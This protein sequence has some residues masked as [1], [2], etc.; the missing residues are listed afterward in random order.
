MFLGKVR[1]PVIVPLAALLL[2]WLPARSQAQTVDDFEARTYTD[3]TSTIPYRLFV[4]RTY[5]PKTA[6]P[7][8]LFLHG[9]GER[10]TDNRRQ[11][12]GQTAPLVFVRPEHQE[13][14][15]CFM[16]APQCPLG[17][18]WD[19]IGRPDPSTWMRLTLEAIDTLFQEF[20]IDYGR[21]YITGLS[22]GGYGTWDVI[23]RYPG[24]FAAAVPMCG[25]GDT[26][27]ADRIANTPIWNFHGALDGTVPVQRS[28][29]MIAAVR[30]VDGDP[31][32]TEYPDLGHNCWDRAYRE[33]DLLPWV[34]SQGWS[35]LYTE[36]LPLETGGVTGSALHELRSGIPWRTQFSVQGVGP[37]TTH[38]DVWIFSGDTLEPT[39][40]A[41]LE[42]IDGYAHAMLETRR[43]DLVP[44]VQGEDFVF[45]FDA[46]T[47]EII[48][49]G[50]YWGG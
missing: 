5:D 39:Y 24:L 41:T 42:V 50:W 6:Y 43:G 21:I 13:R 48:A 22:M 36:L 18:S 26:R 37:K 8:V 16:M 17:G 14:W 9:A 20:S 33:P 49:W 12:T 40:V 29:E 30:A 10:G 34:F 3:G 31:I 25:G 46:A 1:R 32:Y 15:P 4:P 38:L 45:L 44:T 47:Y 35:R 28:R 19:A 11:L 23:G 27:L 2:L 7:L